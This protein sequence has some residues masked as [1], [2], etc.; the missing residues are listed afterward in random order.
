MIETQVTRPSPNTHM[1]VV[2][3]DG[4]A[5]SLI[6]NLYDEEGAT[7]M[8]H[9]GWH[10]RDAYGH[11]CPC[12]LDEPGTCSADTTEGTALY[13]KLQHGHRVFRVSDP[14]VLEALTGVFHEWWGA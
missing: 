11:A 5:V 4:R 2:R 10:E 8:A 1:Y 3:G 12:L 14:V 7:A 13:K 6:V 9:L